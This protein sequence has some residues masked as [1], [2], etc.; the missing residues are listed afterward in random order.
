MQACVPALAGIDGRYLLV[1]RRGANTPA[2]RKLDDLATVFRKPYT[3]PLFGLLD[4]RLGRDAADV[5]T[6]ILG[7]ARLEEEVYLPE[8]AD[9]LIDRLRPAASALMDIAQ[10]ERTA[11]LPYWHSQVAA[12][13]RPIVAD[14]GYAGSIQARLSDITGMPLGGAYF[15][16][17]REIDDN[18]DAASWAAARYHDGRHDDQTP[19]ALQYHLLLESILTAPAGQFSHFELRE[20][21]P[22]ARHRDDALHRRRW[23][24]IEQI[25][26]GAERFVADLVGVA[27]EHTLAF[28]ADAV[29]VQEPLRSVGD[30][31]WQLGAWS[32][33]LGIDDGYTGRGQVATRPGSP[34]ADQ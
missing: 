3:G 34:R 7:K 19:P 14:L 31:H 22:L 27:R 17:T 2:V 12:G 6:Q 9:R 8:M 11:Y 13:D 32:A 23:P 28:E 15:M 29:A 1:S 4:S 21:A 24:V 25:H 26:A 5:A 10:R 20:N 33:A 18:L 16:V 30:G